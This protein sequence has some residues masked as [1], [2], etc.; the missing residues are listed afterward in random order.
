MVRLNKNQLKSLNLSQDPTKKKQKSPMDRFYS[1]V[2]FNK[3]D[4]EDSIVIS[5]DKIIINLKSIKLLSNND[6]L[7]IDN[8]KL[9]KYKN[10]CKDRIKN[11]VN[12]NAIKKWKESS[13][14][15]KIKLEYIYAPS[16]GKK[17]DTVDG[18]TGAFKYLIDGL[19]LSGLIK[20]DSDEYLPVALPKQFKG[21]NE[22]YIL[23]TLIE[24]IDDYYSK[25]FKDLFLKI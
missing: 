6:L 9:T 12:Y 1:V 8:R 7:R 2:D 4:E 25:E 23:L 3:N 24:N 22:I 13:E 14:N 16:H 20:D 19:T 11:L 10:Q 18:I 21:N 15:K 17:M 5:N